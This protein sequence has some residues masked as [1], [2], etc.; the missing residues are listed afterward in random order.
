MST[1]ESQKSFLGRG[2]SFPP[3]FVKNESGTSSLQMSEDEQDIKE[4]LT[5]LL[6]TRLGERV[7][8]PDYGCDLTSMQFEGLSSSVITFIKDMIR[9]NLKKHEPRIK[10]EKVSI[11]TERAGE[12]IVL[13]E[14]D[15]L[16]RTTNTRTNFVYPYYINEATNL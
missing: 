3:R 13:I 1:Q 8:L 9:T 7:M 4:S 16:I 11:R 5:I 14:V 12:G 10:L 15:Y 6:S 2:W